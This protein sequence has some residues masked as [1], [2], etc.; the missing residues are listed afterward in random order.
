MDSV[1]IRVDASYIVG[2]GHVSRCLN[3]AD[4]FKENGFSIIFIGKNNKGNLKDLYKSRGYK[5]HL[6]NY[7]DEAC[8][9]TKKEFNED[10]LLNYKE[11]AKLTID[12]IKK[13]Q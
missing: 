8:S 10:K 6:L 2:S 13:N 5:L 1:A 11:D 3:L 4:E 7:N 12:I 9:K